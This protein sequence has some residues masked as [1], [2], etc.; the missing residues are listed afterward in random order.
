MSFNPHLN[1]YWLDEIH[2]EHDCVIPSRPFRPEMCCQW[3]DRILDDPDVARLWDSIQDNGWVITVDWRN[4]NGITAPALEIEAMLTHD[5]ANRIC[6]SRYFF[7]FPTSHELHY[8][9]YRMLTNIIDCIT[10][11]PTLHTA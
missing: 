11:E 4:Y 2:N 7:A 9:V 1:R 6:S 10:S 5:D 3:L 8:Q